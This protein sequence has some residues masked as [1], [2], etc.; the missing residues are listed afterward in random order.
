MLSEDFYYNIYRIILKIL[1]RLFYIDYEVTGEEN[2]QEAI[3]L[4][5]GVIFASNHISNLD[6]ITYMLIN[7]ANIRFLAK[8]TLFKV[9]VLGWCMKKCGQLSINRMSIDTQAIRDCV[10]FLSKAGNVLCIFPEG[11]RSKTGELQ[12]GKPGCAMIA[13]KTKSIV[14]PVAI[15]G[16]NKI[17]PKNTFFP[18]VS[19]IKI[20]IGK[21]LNLDDYYLKINDIP[22]HDREIYNQITEIIMKEIKNLYDEIR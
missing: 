13:C 3:K 14:I 20:K 18:K 21:H 5:R 12:P 2:L 17:L 6:P 16:T 1:F 11:T 22:A 9:P 7:T 4:N 15:S 10:N 8:N 19:N